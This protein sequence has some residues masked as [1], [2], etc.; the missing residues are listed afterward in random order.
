MDRSRCRHFDEENGF[1]SVDLVD[2]ERKFVVGNNGGA[3][4]KHP[5]TLSEADLRYLSDFDIVHT[6]CYSFI[7]PEMP[8]LK[9]LEGSIVSFDFSNILHEEYLDQVCPYIDFALISCGELSDKAIR[10]TMEFIS[11]YGV[12]YVLASMGA[13]GALLYRDRKYEFQE[14]VKADVVDT[15]G[16][17]DS[18]YT[19]FAINYFMGLKEGR[20]NEEALARES[21]DKAAHF[22]TETCMLDG[23]FGCGEAY[24]D[25]VP[26]VQKAK[27]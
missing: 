11:G 26:A 21:L 1:S 24:E 3:T 19:A 13:R 12:R 9:T 20:A 14:S 27:E 7:E 5:L 16:A 2:G 18:F 8:K 17:G 22:A 10:D 15:L 25:A 4:R 6:S 23:A